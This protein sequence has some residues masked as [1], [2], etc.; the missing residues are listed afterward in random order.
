MEASQSVCQKWCTGRP[1]CVVACIFSLLGLNCGTSR[2]LQDMILFQ[3]DASI[4]STIDNI[5][6]QWTT[7]HGQ[8][9]ALLPVGSLSSKQ[10]DCDTP[11]IAADLAS[12]NTSL[13]ERHHQ[14][15]LLAVSAPA[16]AAH[17]GDWLHALPIS[18]CGLR[19][20]DEAVRVRVGL[21]LG[22]RLYELHQCPCDTKVGPEGTN[23]LA[24]RRSQVTDWSSAFRR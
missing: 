15:R 4:D 10:H 22:V 2:D 21:R 20:D 5:L 11:T 24:C 7:A 6:V 17:S 1:A 14:A 18:S 12:L 13:P 3:C 19:L 16:A 23:G 9:G 8:S